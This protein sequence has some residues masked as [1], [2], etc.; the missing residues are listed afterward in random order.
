MIYNERKNGNINTILRVYHEHKNQINVEK[1]L[2][3]NSLRQSEVTFKGGLTED[4]HRW[5]RLTPSFAPNLVRNMLNEMGA[6]P[7]KVVLDPFT[8]KGTTII[9]C[10]RRGFESVGVEVNPLLHWISKSSV[11]W[12]LD[13]AKL[14]QLKNE[15]IEKHTR[16]CNSY[17]NKNLND[18]INQLC[19]DIP[20]IHRVDK[21]WNND[22][23]KD[24]L[25]I[26]KTISDLE[27]ED[28]YKDV[29]N[30]ALNSILVNVAN[31]SLGRLQ[32]HFID[33]KNEKIDVNHLFYEQL[34]FLFTDLNK[35]KH[36]SNIKS[37]VYLG[38]STRIHNILKN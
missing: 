26:K 12:D 35:V 25:I 38:D 17:K 3:K 14:N 10:K 13:E 30:L 37:T 5:F 32:L 29:F 27:C 24:L 15:L 7:T 21:W 19:I 9:E 22:I 20:K 18:T 8:G 16:L 4:V 28:T 34:T 2:T 33:R 11:N 31:V 6:T 1:K 23:L 36:N